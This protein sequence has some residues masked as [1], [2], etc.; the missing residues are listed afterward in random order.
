ML[1]GP[2]LCV[3]VER[4]A[5]EHGTDLN[6]EVGTRIPL[7]VGLDADIRLMCGDLPMFTGKMGR[8]SGNIAVQ[9]SE[10]IDRERGN[11]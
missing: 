1:R 2:G 3:P 11:T 7:T 10:R 4:C 8:R 5:A 9:I 6:L